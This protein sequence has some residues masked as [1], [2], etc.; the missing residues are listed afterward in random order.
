MKTVRDELDEHYPDSPISNRIIAEM[1]YD[2]FEKNGV[3]LPDVDDESPDYA[4]QLYLCFLEQREEINNLSCD[5]LNH[6]RALFCSLTGIAW[7]MFSAPHIVG[8]ITLCDIHKVMV[9]FETL[10]NRIY[11]IHHNGFLAGEEA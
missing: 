2:L 7:G 5:L 3:D 10:Q 6:E 4:E 8:S 9:E 1:H 11:D